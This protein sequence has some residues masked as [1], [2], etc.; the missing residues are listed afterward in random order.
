[1]KIIS[2]NGVKTKL[3]L[4]FSLISVSQIQLLSQSNKNFWGMANLADKYIVDITVVTIDSWLSYY[5]WA[6]NSFGL[7]EANK[8]LPDSSIIP[9][10][11]WSY[12]KNTKL[13]NNERSRLITLER[14]SV[15]TGQPIPK[16]MKKCKELIN[17]DSFFKNQKDRKCP[18]GSYP[19]IGLSY[20]QVIEFCK[21]RTQQV[22]G[23]SI[24]YRLPTEKE[25]KEIAGYCLKKGEKINGRPDSTC[26]NSCSTFNYRLTKESPNF[27]IWDEKGM[28]L[29]TV[30]LFDAGKS[31]IYDIFG[32]VSQMTME[33]GIS[34]G[35]N[36]TLYA[37]ECHVDSIQEYQTP[38]KWLG[39]RC[40]VEIH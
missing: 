28:S 14:L 9:S 20:A 7:E 39:F 30:A 19:I 21:W 1:M 37:S 2:R 15:H 22:G 17:Q 36:Y 29:K 38:E 18:L 4:F 25:W 24:I 11:L 16:T 12:I 40:I 5:N 32:N 33:E 31:G 23:D 34:K 3:I 35:G 8:V 27:G 6:Y 10:H 26:G 13:I